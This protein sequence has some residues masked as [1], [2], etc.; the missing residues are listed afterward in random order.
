MD[1]NLEFH[2][3]VHDLYMYLVDLIWFGRFED[4]WAIRRRR[5]GECLFPLTQKLLR[6]LKSNLVG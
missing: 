4:A 1:E 3:K 2:I 5:G 6:I